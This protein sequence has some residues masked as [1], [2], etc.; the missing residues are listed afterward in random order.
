MLQAVQQLAGAESHLLLHLR[1]LKP[2][3]AATLV[4]AAK[5]HGK[6]P[7]VCDFPACDEELLAVLVHSHPWNAAE[8]VLPPSDCM[9]RSEQRPS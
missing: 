7:T 9:L 4:V 3:V 1:S 6:V 8:R 5:G 2:V